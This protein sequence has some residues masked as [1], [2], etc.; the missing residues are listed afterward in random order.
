MD[1]KIDHLS[2]VEKEISVTF[3]AE[4]VTEKL[5]DSYSRLAKTS[6]VNGF[7]KGRVPLHIIKQMYGKDVAHD[8]ESQ[9]INLGISKSTSEENLQVITHPSIKEMN[10]IKENDVFSFSF[11]VEVFPVTDIKEIDFEL[12]YTPVLYKVE[13]LNEELSAI[14]N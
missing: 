12:E 14:A 2:G 13:M 7:R 9:F 4:E 1:Y 3:S 6:K 10:G 8:I 11:K 5:S